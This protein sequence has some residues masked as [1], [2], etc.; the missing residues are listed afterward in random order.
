MKNKKLLVSALL[1]V[2]TLAIGAVVGI[3]AGKKS[4]FRAYANPVQ[5]EWHHYAKTNPTAL[6]KGIRE[7]WVQCGGSYQF[8]APEDVDIVDKG[9]SYDVSEFEAN[10]PRYLSY[11]YDENHA[12]LSAYDYGAGMYNT[13]SSDFVNYR[14]IYGDNGYDCKLYSNGGTKILWRIDLPRIDFTKY[15]TVTMNVAA[16]VIDDQYG[17]YEG[18]MMGPEADNL[19]YHTVFGGAKDKGKITLSLTGN[20]VHMAF[21]SLEYENQLAFENTFTDPD[22]V[23]GL[24]SAYF[25]TEDLYDRFLNFSNITL[26]TASSSVDVCSYAGDTSKIGVVNG[27]AALAGSVDYGIIGNGYATNDTCVV[28]DGNANPGAAVFTLPA[29]NFGEYSQYGNIS[30]KF[31]V[32]NNNE[33][34][35]FGSGDDKVDLG[36]N[37]SNSESNNNNGYVNWEMI[38][39]D[40]TAYVHNVNTDTNIFVTLTSGM[41]N[42]TE[43]IVLSGGGTSAYR[44]YLFVDYYWKLNADYPLVAPESPMDVYSYNGDTSKLGVQNGTAKKPNAADYSIVSN[45]YAGEFTGMCLEGNANPGAAVLTLPAFNMKAFLKVGKISFKFGVKNNGEHMYFGSGDSKV[46]LGTNSAT[47]QSENN[48]GYVNW[49]MVISADGA[50]VH[51]VNSDQNINIT[52]GSGVRDGSQSIVLSGGGTSIYRVYLVTDFYW[53]K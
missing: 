20:G 3:A 23:N 18:N 26:S 42:G 22:V 41:M 53:S 17:W 47:S 29:Y 1:G 10:D 11:Q 33:H 43:G 7:Y 4:G 24:R 28:V 21:N 12:P 49:E 48:S 35:Y 45:G 51:N 52:L 19:T 40:G 13:T 16:P 34:M 25:Y 15:P 27:T 50:Y 8:T 2:S 6:Q 38:I 44:R 46:D 31:G 9:T 39:A 37:A 30:F 36:A 32:R 5:P 14:I